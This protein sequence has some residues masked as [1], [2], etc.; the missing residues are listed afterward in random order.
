M[1]KSFLKL[2][3]LFV[4]FLFLACNKEF[5]TAHSPEYFPNKIGDQWEYEVTDSS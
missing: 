5:N 4:I 3:F 2:Q 1:K